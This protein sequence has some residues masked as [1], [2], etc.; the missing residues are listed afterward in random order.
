M[1]ATSI[2]DMP[3]DYIDKAPPNID[4]LRHIPQSAFACNYSI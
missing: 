4:Q 1:T 3:L 2:I